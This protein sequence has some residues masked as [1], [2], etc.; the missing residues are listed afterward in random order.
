MNITDLLLH[1][2]HMLGFDGAFS[3]ELWGDA[4]LKQ[5]ALLGHLHQDQPHQLPHVHPAHHLLKAAPQTHIY[6]QY[7]KPTLSLIAT[8]T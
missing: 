4:A 2:R 5:L 6:H 3:Q 7:C 1:G 8:N